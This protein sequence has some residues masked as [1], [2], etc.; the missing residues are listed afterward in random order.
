MNL[1]RY[2]PWNLLGDLNTVFDR[3]YQHRS[4]VDKTAVETCQWTPAVDI[5]EEK[6]RYLIHADLPG[7]KKDEV[8]ITMKDNVLTISGERNE[9]H[10]VEK[11]NYSR[12]E[13][14][15]GNFYR[16][17]SLPDT[18]DDENIQAAMKHGVLEVSLPKKKEQH[19]QIA[20]DVQ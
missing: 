1:S 4:D 20:I 11:D 16:R 19:R 2:E 13:R 17:F 9:E 12:F 18:V 5:V 14:V 10:N 3:M 7:V 15:K 8:S 6:D